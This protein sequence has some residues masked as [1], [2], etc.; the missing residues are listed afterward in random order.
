MSDT[1]RNIKE[2]A[3]EIYANE[4]TE[5]SMSH[6]IYKS[7]DCGAWLA[8]ISASRFTLRFPWPKPWHSWPAPLVRVI[9]ALHLLTFLDRLLFVWRKP[10]GR[11][12]VGVA[13]GSIVEGS[14]VDIGPYEF[15]FPFSMKVFWAA[16]GEIE[17]EADW[18]WH[19]ANDPLSANDDED[20]DYEDAE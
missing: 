16:L 8:F 18:E 12:V 4:P 13:I 5:D 14:D 15:F 1:V 9:E 19:R 2:L 20:A 3:A 11:R 6:R 10:V 7:T 17:S